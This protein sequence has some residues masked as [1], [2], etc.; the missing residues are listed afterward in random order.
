M[1]KRAK[2][3]GDILSSVTIAVIFIVILLLV[4][5]AASS[6]RHGADSRAASDDQ[7]AVLSYVVTAVKDANG[8]KVEP[9][10]LTGYPGVVIED[11]NTGYAQKIYLK[12]GTLLHEY[13]KADS[14]V[15]PEEAL[16]IGTTGSFEASYV[17][18]NVLRIK[19]DE[20]ASYV[21]VEH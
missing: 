1:E 7:R 3:I 6:Y 9:K 4:V 14:D 2:G 13:S 15:R 10:T 5:F 18:D 21:N 8:G 12:D 11:G 19:T 20:G 16:E 17:D